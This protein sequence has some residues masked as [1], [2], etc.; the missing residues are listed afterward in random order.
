[1][2]EH[3]TVRELSSN[4]NGTIVHVYPNNSTFE[5][6]LFDKDGNTIEVKTLDSTQIEK[7]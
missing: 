3:D 2:K 7:R 1:M 6:E 4:L 5:V